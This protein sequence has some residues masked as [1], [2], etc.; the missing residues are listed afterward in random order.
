MSLQTGTQLATTTEPVVDPRQLVVSA[1]YVEGSGLGAEPSV[2]HPSDIR[3]LSDIG[4]IIDN[5]DKIMSLDGLVRL[6][7]IIG[8]GFQL[9]GLRVVDERGRK[10]GKVSGYSVD[11]T[12]YSVIQVYTEQSLIRSLGALGSTIHRSQI[13]SV[14]NEQLIVQSPSVRDE[15]KK[16]TDDATK[17]FVNP[18]RGG[19]QPD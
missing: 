8:F 7:E 13:V 1:F 15:V 9:S 17:A 6:N 3:E 16:V 2:V 11:S 10:L 5:A 14:N 12:S 4:M 19:A 18:F